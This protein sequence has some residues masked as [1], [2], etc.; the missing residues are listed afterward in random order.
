MASNQ[1]IALRDS[2][3]V[4]AGDNLLK[5]RDNKEAFDVAEQMLSIRLPSSY[6]DYVKVFGPGTLAYEYKIAA[7]GF[8]DQYWHTNLVSLNDV[9][10]CQFLSGRTGLHRDLLQRNIVFF[11][12]IG[13]GDYVGWNR[14]E[15]T[16]PEKG[17]YQIVRCD[18]IHRTI[19]T[20]A[21][22][23][24]QFITDICLAPFGENEEDILAHRSFT[25]EYDLTSLM[26]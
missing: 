7:P 21:D 2:L 9:I 16:D 5:P 10:Y 4:K 22:A 1:W 12:L 14:R 15:V 8:G 11:C 18:R 3:T 17:E 23:F 13:D 24:S 19:E 6:C 25:P 20:I 26:K